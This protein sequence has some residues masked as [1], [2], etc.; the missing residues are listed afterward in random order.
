MT[1]YIYLTLAIVGELI[2]TTL[3]KYTDGFTKPL[4]SAGSLIAYGVCFYFFAK[5][6]TSIKLSVAYASWSGLG[7]VAAALLSVFLFNEQLNLIGI[8]GIVLIVVGVIILNMF[9]AAH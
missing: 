9:G 4:P 6:L 2:G 5:S 8:L 1:G 7:I 3:L